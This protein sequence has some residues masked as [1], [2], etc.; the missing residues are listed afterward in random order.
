[1]SE[2]ANTFKIGLFTVVASG[3]ILTGVS[4]LGAGAYFER[5]IPI[6]T[7]LT[8]SVD[9]LDVGAPVKFRGVRVGRV[10]HISFAGAVYP[11]PPDQRM[12]RGYV[13]IVIEMKQDQFDLEFASDPESA[14]ARAI[15]AGLRLRLTS[16]GLVG[17][18]FLEFAFLGEDAGEPLTISWTPESFYVPSSQS[19]RGQITS[20]A[21]RIAKQLEEADIAATI[22]GIGALA[23]NLDRKVG[24]LDIGTL[25]KD[26]DQLL[27][28]LRQNSERVQA[29]LNNPAIDEAIA[30]AGGLKQMPETVEHIRRAAAGIDQIINSDDTKAMIANLGTTMQAAAPATDQLRLLLTRIDR[31]IAQQQ[32]DIEGLLSSLRDA[33]Q[34]IQELSED[35]KE[36]PSRILFGR[37]PAR[38]ATPAKGGKK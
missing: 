26:A 30:G 32:A 17:Q 33:A 25:Q 24:E 5:T 22:K 13:R 14:L 6:E 38:D 3:L 21:E 10:S 12:E 1:M 2:H 34:N 4:V 27:K 28:G 29:I 9:G 7:Y 16:S 20:A 23:S 11:V 18:T 36:N 15:D 35:A 8:E 31:L 37:P 19:I